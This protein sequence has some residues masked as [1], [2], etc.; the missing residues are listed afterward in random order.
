MRAR[1]L[2]KA[3]QNQLDLDDATYRATLQRLTGKASSKELSFNE[4]QRCLDHFKKAG[5][6]PGSKGTRKQLDGPY[7]KKL[8]A[9]WIAGWNLGLVRNKDDGA[10]LAFVKR[11]TGIDHTRFLHKPA[12]ATRAIEALKGWLAREGQVDW[13]KSKTQT[14]LHQLNGWRIVTAQY[15]MLN[16]AIDTE[17]LQK[18][19]Q[20]I[21][22]ISG[23]SHLTRMVNEADWIPVMNAFG[24]RIREANQ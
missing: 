15:Q 19:K 4:V 12:D 21:L 24:T 22:A 14:P 17:S 8:Q 13:S 6:K 10:L 2:L 20:E 23:A 9:L 3:A 1:G 7:A 18:F 11:Q 16:G 5:F